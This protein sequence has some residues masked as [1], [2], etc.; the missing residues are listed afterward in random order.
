MDYEKLIQSRNEKNHYARHMGVR[1]VEIKEGYARA[2][3]EV[4]EEFQNSA[5]V[6][7]GCLFTLADVATGSAA[8]SRGSSMT[9]ISG[10]L[11][12][13]SPA[14]ASEKITAVSKEI[15]RGKKISF[16]EVEIFGE[17]GKLV[18]KGLIR[19]ASISSMTGTD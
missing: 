1:V 2:V 19:M 17:T 13:L 10:S 12:Y 18:A 14:S 3:M 4:N 16:F 5:N 15:K 8:A 6:G 11:D 9:T 7:D